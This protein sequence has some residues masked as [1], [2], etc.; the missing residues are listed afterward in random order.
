MLPESHHVKSFIQKSYGK[1]D[2]GE[3]RDS[4]IPTHFPSERD[5]LLASYNDLSRY[6]VYVL[7]G[8]NHDTSYVDTMIKTIDCLTKLIEQ[9]KIKLNQHCKILIKKFFGKNIF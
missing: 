4:H 6:S 9:E 8:Y 1:S 2:E 7:N 3:Q 5:S